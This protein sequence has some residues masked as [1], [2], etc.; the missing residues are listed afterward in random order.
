M[1]N[2]KKYLD[3]GSPDL[4]RSA[5][6][7]MNDND[8]ENVDLDHLSRPEERRDWPGLSQSWQCER[9]RVY[10]ALGYDQAGF[11]WSAKQKFDIGHF[12]EAY[13]MNALRK[14]WDIED[15]I[16]MGQR[17]V[18]LEIEGEEITGHPD[19]LLN[20]RGQKYLVECKS[21]SQPQF[22]ASWNDTSVVTM[23]NDQGVLAFDKSNEDHWNWWGS[24]IAQVHAYCKAMDVDDILF[25]FVGR[26]HGVESAYF[27]ADPDIWARV[28]DRWRTVMNA[29]KAGELPPRPEGVQQL[30]AD[31]QDV[32]KGADS[33]PCAYCSFYNECHSDLDAVRIVDDVSGKS[34]LLMNGGKQ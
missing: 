16:F 13:W 11:E 28:E 7:W 10:Q 12:I 30:R 22:D 25:L 3:C 5:Q 2:H 8:F 34:Y 26:D 23:I 15:D 9:K 21:M 17:E 18:K 1:T 14:V 33:F 29:Y 24:Y 27:E 19:G 20:D 31:G 6:S 32:W 4:A